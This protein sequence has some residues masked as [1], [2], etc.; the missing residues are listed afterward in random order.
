MVGDQRRVGSLDDRELVLETLEVL[1]SQPIG[2]AHGLVAGGGEP[3]RP[4]IERVGRAHTP[5]DAMHHAVAR[6][7]LRRAREL[8]E[9]EIR[10]GAAL[11]VRI[12]QV[13]DAG[14]VLVDGL[15]DE[16]KAHQA[17]VERHV[18]AVRPR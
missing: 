4:E 7:T 11:L 6:P 15:L 8:E 5:A 10:A 13:I 18:L 9:G 3:L 2:V 17:C 14:L 12:E 1:E 16:A